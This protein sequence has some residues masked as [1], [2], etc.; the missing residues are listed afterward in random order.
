MK[1]KK[2]ID[3]VLALVIA[4][5]ALTYSFSSQ[6]SEPGSG[7]LGFFQN[8]FS[9]GSSHYSL[10]SRRNITLPTDA[11][12]ETPPL[13]A[14]GGFVDMPG[15]YGK[16]EFTRLTGPM[17]EGGPLKHSYSRR[18]AIDP[19][20]KYIL[21]NGFLYDLATL[22]EYKKIPLSSEY[23]ASMIQED[24]FFGV[25]GNRLKKW[26]AVTGEITDIWGAPE[27]ADLTIGRWEGQQSWDDRFIALSWVDGTDQIATINLE[28]GALV[29]QISSNNF[30]GDLNWVDVSPGGNFVVV[31]SSSG[32]FRYN[33]D[34]SNQVLLN[35]NQ[36]GNAHSDLM[37]DKQG[38]EVIVQEGN[39]HEGD[40]SF[41]ILETNELHQMNL[42]N[43][44]KQNPLTYPSSAAH[45]SG[46]ATDFSG[47]VLVSLNKDTGMRSIFSA[48]LVP[49]QKKIFS[50]GHTYSTG[51]SYYS[52][53]HTTISSDGKTIIWTSD[54]MKPGSTYEFLARIKEEVE[55]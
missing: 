28:T 18:S 22:T 54:W 25:S 55:P 48:D 23:V 7:F 12:P 11:Q 33:I 44:R 8:L 46:Q 53:A 27:A 30:D 9:G 43:T 35:T 38:N 14:I 36:T 45:I 42:V 20:N 51:D 10:K 19:F 49:G 37:L 52:Q 34:F 40:I 1:L 29:G 6:A 15:T 26:N 31:G 5:I 16:V 4:S 21:F 47:R 13:P 17:A 41:T 3:W 24:T 2:V 50:W 39:F 32:V